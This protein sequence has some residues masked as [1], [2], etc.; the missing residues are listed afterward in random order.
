MTPHRPSTLLPPPGAPRTAEIAHDRPA[1]GLSLVIEPFGGPPTRVALPREGELL[2]GGLWA[3]PQGDGRI[4]IPDPAVSARH[5]RIEVRGGRARI[6]DL[7][8]RNGT[9]VGGARVE[10]A[11]L[12]IGTCAI[13][14]R[15]A[16]ALEET[17]PEIDDFE[18]VLGDE[19]IPGAIGRSPAMRRLAAAVH[20]YAGLSASVLVRG[21]SG[22]GKEVVARA[23]HLLSP[24]SAGPFHAINLGALPRELAEAELF[25]H[26]R[27]AFTG[28]A[29]ARAGVFE[30][31]DGGTLLL[32]EL[33][34]LPLDMQAKLLRVLETGEVR[35]LGARSARR[36]DVRVI[37]ATWAPLEQRIADGTFREDLFHRVAVLMI[38]VPPLRERRSDVP[39]IAEELLARSGDF[40]HK[41][42]SP[43]AAS[44]LAAEP[45]PGNVRELRNVLYRAA[46]L[47]HGTVIDASEIARALVSRSSQPPP[48]ATCDRRTAVSLFEAHG[49]IAAAARAAGVPRETM[50]DWIRAARRP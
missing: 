8:S 15:S 17:S 9:W 24:R 47:T 40:A 38:D 31:S 43:A 27:G 29:T 39:A 10:A 25:G 2:L 26:E 32:D 28:A 19:P 22:S 1:R 35:R 42:L 4:G 37:A 18:E 48:R 49:S 36:V 21:E 30:L 3:A 44:R 7:G 14:G 50:R 34:E 16:V 13:V 46:A 12:S 23:L 20:A 6:V 11:A 33:G 5:A 41:S 45:W